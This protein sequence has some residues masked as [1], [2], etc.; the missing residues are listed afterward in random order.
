MTGRW[1]Q[2]QKEHLRRRL[3]E[4]AMEL[5]EKNGYE[6][7]SVQ[8]IADRVKVAKGTFFN[9]FPTKE[10]VLRAWYDDITHQ[11]LA[12]A[13]K[14]EM[15][16][17]EDA[18][19]DLI[20]DMVGRAMRTP[21]LLIAKASHTANPL[22]LEAEQVQDDLTDA[23]LLEQCRDGQ[24]RGELAPDVDIEFFAGLVGA[25]LTGTS[26][27]WVTSRAG[28]DFPAVISERVR[29]LF[30]VVRRPEA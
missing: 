5:F 25:V 15:S 26:R 7:T 27:E 17:A 13:G 29:F 12:A 2:E 14:R 19:H 8:E 21:K 20:L 16:S 9:H 23:F 1:R 30:R 10:H 24:A 18:V 4:A 6:R 28:F 11:A 22:L 3:Y